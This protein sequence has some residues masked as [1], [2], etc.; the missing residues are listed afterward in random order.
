[1]HAKLCFDN[2]L[3]LLLYQVFQSRHVQIQ[4]KQNK[5]SLKAFLLVFHMHNDS[6]FY[7]YNDVMYFN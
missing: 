3:L 1:M 2:D 4:S 6:I 7:P 5:F